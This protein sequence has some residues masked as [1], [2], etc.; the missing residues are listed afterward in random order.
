MDSLAL[1]SV[2][3]TLWIL[4]SWKGNPPSAAQEVTCFL[5]SSKVRN[6]ASKSSHWSVPWDT[7]IQYTSSSYLFVKLY[8]SLILVSRRWTVRSKDRGLIPPRPRETFLLSTAS[9]PALKPLSVLS[10]FILQVYSCR[11]VMLTI[12]LL[13]VPRLRMLEAITSY[14]YTFS[15]FDV[16]LSTRSNLPF[17]IILPSTSAK[18]SQ[19]WRP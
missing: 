9:L 15:R 16:W 1:C 18:S 13:L 3:P 17:Y 8:S 12:P 10:K 2:W 4:E 7:C 11:G 6:R 19:D 5:Y 14:P